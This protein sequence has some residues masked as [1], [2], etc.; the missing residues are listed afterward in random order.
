MTL[1]QKVGDMNRRE[2]TQ[3]VD[4]RIRQQRGWYRLGDAANIQETLASLRQN[5]YTPPEGTPSVVEMIRED[6]DR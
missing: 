5:R 6:R 4:D 3:F 2:L 1:E